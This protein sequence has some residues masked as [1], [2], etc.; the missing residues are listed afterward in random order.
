MRRSRNS[1]NCLMFM[2]QYPESQQKWTS[3][4]D[5]CDDQ[6][7]TP[8]LSLQ[9]QLHLALCPPRPSSTF[10]PIHPA[11]PSTASEPAT[12]GSFNT[13]LG[14]VDSTQE[15]GSSPGSSI[16]CAQKPPATSQ[17]SPAS[18]QGTSTQSNK[19]L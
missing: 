10:K 19:V 2:K 3:W 6:V 8:Y 15:V 11:V 17:P 4:K 16:P 7:C 1:Q 13:P 12:K 9:Y 14:M 18:T 5:T